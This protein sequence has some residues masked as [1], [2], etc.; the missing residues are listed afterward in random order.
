MPVKIIF[1]AVSHIFSL[2]NHLHV[3]RQEL[4]DFG[5]QQRIMRTTENEGVYQRV[6]GKNAIDMLFHK[7]IG[8]RLIK[9]PVFNERHPHGTG[10]AGDGELRM[11]LSHLYFIGSRLDGSFR[12]QNADVAGLRE[13]CQALCGGTDDAEHSSAGVHLR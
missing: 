2:G 10:F 1:Q 11:E 13:S 5:D 9:F 4:I 7:I 6:F 3:S 8:T 12:S